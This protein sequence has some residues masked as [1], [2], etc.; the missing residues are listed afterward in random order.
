MVGRKDGAALHVDLWLMSC[1]V[2]KRDMEVAML[3][4]LIERA[5]AAGVETIYGYY[6]PTA[7]NAM[8]AEHYDKL[9]FVHDP[10]TSDGERKAWALSVAGY[11]KRNRHITVK[12]A[13]A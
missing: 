3:D 9:G 1:R 6:I 12:G 2:L 13:P 11:E 7:K 8:V 4:A 10:S 5:V